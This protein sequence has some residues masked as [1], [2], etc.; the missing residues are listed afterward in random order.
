VAGPEEGVG[1]GVG[2]EPGAGMGVGV[3]AGLVSVVFE[4]VIIATSRRR[5]CWGLAGQG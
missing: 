5:T 3:R 2:A 1:L 4:V